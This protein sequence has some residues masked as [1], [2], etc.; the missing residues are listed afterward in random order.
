[1]TINTVIIPSGNSKNSLT[2]AYAHAIAKSKISDISLKVLDISALSF[3]TYDLDNNPPSDW[4]DFR[5]AVRAA[6]AVI[7]MTAEYNRSEPAVLKNAIDIG[8]RPQ[9]DNV[10][11]NKPTAV[12]SLSPG[13]IGGY[14]ANMSVRQS[15][16][17][18]NTPLLTRPEVF[19]SHASHSKLTDG[20]LN[21]ATADLVDIALKNL[22]T[23]AKKYI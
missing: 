4:V 2:R 21:Q 3:Y 23:L 19:L 17:H 13:A 5:N 16:M 7:I 22:I 14:G 8:S 18:L 12:F 6:H 1:M 11:N 20:N 15:L 10:W 9:Q